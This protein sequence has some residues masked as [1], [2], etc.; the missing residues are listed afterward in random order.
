MVHSAAL[1]RAPLL[2][3]QGESGHTCEFHILEGTRWVIE[4]MLL[5]ASEREESPKTGVGEGIGLSGGNRLQ[6]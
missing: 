2:S 4:K 5:R 3:S 6:Q 1:L